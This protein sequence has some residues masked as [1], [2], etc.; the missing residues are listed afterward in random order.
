MAASIFDTLFTF[1]TNLLKESGYAGVFLLMLMESATL[2]IPS[3][4]VLPFAGY[5]VYNGQF[6][7]WIAVVVASIGSLVGTLIDYWI[8]FYLGRKAI[9]S[10]GRIIRLNE[11]HL[12]TSERW[13]SK[14]GNV[15]VFLARFV[16]LIRTL[17]AFPA[18]IAEMSLPKFIAYSIVGIFIW[19][20][21]LIYLGELAGQNSNA[22]IDS[23][24]NVFTPI[25]IAAVVIAL[26]A[27]LFFWTRR[28]SQQKTTSES[29]NQKKGTGS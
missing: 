16:P 8:G 11:G 10:Y 23:L 12:K 25:E 21:L 17:V 28:R 20:A 7:F 2:P 5:L 29:E 6:D 15:T 18:G 22:I 9:I 1:A 26:V 19:D 24:H 3:E 14:Y 4:V 13:F 27:L